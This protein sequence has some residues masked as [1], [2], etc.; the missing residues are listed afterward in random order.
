MQERGPWSR[1]GVDGTRSQ[2]NVIA[3]VLL[4]GIVAMGATAVVLAGSIAVD[5]SQGESSFSVAEQTMQSLDSE[6]EQVASSGS[7]GSLDIPAFENGDV[8]IDESAG[9]ITVTLNKGGA[10][11]SVSKQL[12]TI[13]YEQEGQTLGYQSGGI[14]SKT[15]TE[16]TTAISPPAVEF[17][18]SSSAPT[19]SIPVIAVRGGSVDSEVEIER[20]TVDDL[21]SLFDLG[22]T[23]L[24][25]ADAPRD[26]SME[27]ESL[28][29][30]L[31]G[32]EAWSG[33]ER[34]FAEHAR[35]GVLRETACMTMV[36]TDDWK[37]VHFVDHDEGQL[38]DLTADPDETEN[39]WDDPGAQ[40]AK[41]DL[42]DTLLEWRVESGLRTADW[43]AEYR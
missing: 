29:P 35:D 2:S 22:P 36:R 25:I 23:V 5:Q 32:D 43:A 20:S 39:L 26:D 41:R 12:G 7:T 30:A 6:I 19:L 1:P 38:F 14:F 9:E 16:G 27:A 11:H 13:E 34:V 17:R 42:L 10:S 8:S 24:D 31:E 40:D 37:L 15:G 33:R 21:V 3:V 28:V 4:A 18:T